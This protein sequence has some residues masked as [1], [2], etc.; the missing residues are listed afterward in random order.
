MRKPAH[1]C[2]SIAFLALLAISLFVLTGCG[3]IE[4]T[5][6][7]DPSLV[8]I[9]REA[10]A[11]KTI[12]RTSSGINTVKERKRIT[13]N[14]QYEDIDLDYLEMSGG[15]ISGI[16]NLMAIQLNAG[17]ELT[18]SAES[19][20]QSGNLSLVLLSP[21]NK[22]LHEFPTGAYDIAKITAEVDGIYF[23]RAGCESFTGVILLERDF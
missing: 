5:N 20:V 15:I 6:G 3:H 2:K 11:G 22:I 14:T 23:I 4:D 19:G 1:P 13:I 21:D 16:T 8:T 12:S 10:L 9:T 18:I 17:Q 7:E